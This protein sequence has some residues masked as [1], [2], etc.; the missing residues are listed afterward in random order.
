M[1]AVAGRN[2]ALPPYPTVPH[3]AYSVSYARV[4]TKAQL[5]CLP[6]TASDAYV[7]LSS[8]R[9]KVFFS[10]ILFSAKSYLLLLP[11]CLFSPTSF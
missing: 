2:I 4:L 8:H 3:R 9:L 7:H 6:C 10:C 5:C 11:S 1:S